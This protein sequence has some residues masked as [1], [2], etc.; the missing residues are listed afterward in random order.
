MIFQFFLPKSLDLICCFSPLEKIHIILCRE[1]RLYPL[2]NARHVAKS[3]SEGAFKLGS[4]ILLNFR[5]SSKTRTKSTVDPM[6][7]HC[8]KNQRTS[9]PCK[10]TCKQFEVC[11]SVV[12]LGSGKCRISFIQ[13]QL[14]FDFFLIKLFTYPRMHL[15][16]QK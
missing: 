1:H 11:E 10:K 5:M 7:R 4:T 2:A 9:F 14:L 8:S 16:E 12:I 3:G 6:K 13:N 15:S